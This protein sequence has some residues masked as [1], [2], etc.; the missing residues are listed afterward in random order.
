MDALRA[1]LDS[2]RRRIYQEI[3][4]RR[5]IPADEV[6]RSA[7]RRFWSALSPAVRLDVLR[8]TDAAI[9]QRV[10]GHMITLLKAE[11]WAEVAYV[12]CGISASS[13]SFLVI[14]DVR[15]SDV[16]ARLQFVCGSSC[17][18]PISDYSVKS[19]HWLKS[20]TRR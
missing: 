8:F 5:A 2:I 4:A 9:V 11:P 17:C 16:H 15:K 18:S 3:A 6:D 13:P 7:L 19:L 14:I 12:L 1:P 10:H 20:Q